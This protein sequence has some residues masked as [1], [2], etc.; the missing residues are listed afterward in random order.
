MKV[1]EADVEK[2][3]KLAMFEI[4]D[5]ERKLYRGQFEEILNLV[6]HLSQAGTEGVEETCN[7]NAYEN[8]TRKDE[9]RPFENR[10]AIL[11]NAPAREFDLFKVRKVI[12]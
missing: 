4:T 5:T 9:P 7:I 8:V 6:N 1:T 3:S 12:E 11:A 10:A 2:I